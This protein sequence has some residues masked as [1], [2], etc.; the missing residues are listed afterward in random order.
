MIPASTLALA[1]ATHALVRRHLFPGDGCEAAA[2]L[3]CTKPSGAPRDRLLV[4][5]ALPVPHD[6]CACREPDRIVWPGAWIEKA[7]DAAEADDLA[8]VLIHSHPGG[9]FAFSQADDDSDR[10]VI[11]GLF[12]ALGPRHGSAIMTPDGAVRARLYGP[13]MRPRQVDLVSVAGDN[14]S[15]F[16]DDDPRP[17]A[18]PARPP[19]FTGAMTAELNRLTAAVIGVSGTGSIVAEQAARLGFGRVVM[20]DFD[21]VEPRNLN[22]ILNATS[23]DASERAL[24]VE[25]F[26][27]AIRSHRGDGVAVPIVASVATREAVLSA[28]AADVL[29]CC[30]D[31]LEARQI[32]DLVASAFLIPLVDM[33]V[34]I[35]MRRA[36]A[37]VAIADVVGRVDF[38]QPGGSSLLD[39]GVY[40][41]ESLRAEYLRRAAP[42]AHRQELEAGY[43]KGAIEEAPAVIT[44][45]MRTAATAMNEFIARAYPFRLDANAG[46]A[47][48]QFSLAACEEEHLAEGGFPRSDQPQFGR[49]ASEPLLGLPALRA[50]KSARAS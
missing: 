29:F 20:V 46:F 17:R 3:L 41:P 14:L 30:V 18:T 28:G 5:E 19:A 25:M 10:R 21:K 45:N 24:K 35:P 48:T 37:G 32:A 33:G 6:A 50:P 2:I 13:D 12:H 36:G 16:W 4:R 15:F 8:L 26:A 31:T 9:L 38:V 7:V 49:G 44:L 39:R 23:R 27:D 42:D 34:V 43:I 1:G 11:P 40:S 22:R 47:R